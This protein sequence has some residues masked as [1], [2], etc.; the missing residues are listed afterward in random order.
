ME[1]NDLGSDL[2]GESFKSLPKDLQPTFY[3]ENPYRI[4]FLSMI[5]F[6]FY[7]F[8]WFY[9]HW[10]HYKRRA[11]ECKRQNIEGLTIF[12]SDVDIIPFWS[13]FFSGYYIVGTARRIRDRL[14]SINS[15]EFRTGPWWA[16]WLFA[17]G[18]L[19]TSGYE[20]TEDIGMNLLILLLS[21]KI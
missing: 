21:P 4:L 17:F 9:R 8:L 7:N 12:V 3:V 5:T 13:T 18:T 14:R 1:G 19:P 6:G 2:K 10:R 20:A 15:P 11:L 16:F